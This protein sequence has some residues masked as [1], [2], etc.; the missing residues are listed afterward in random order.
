MG[1]YMS[2]KVNVATSCARF[3]TCYHTSAHVVKPECTEDYLKEAYD[4]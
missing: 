2:F 4:V 1:T 3:E